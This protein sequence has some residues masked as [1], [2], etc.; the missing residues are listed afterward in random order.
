VSDTRVFDRPAT[1]QSFFE[2][3]IGDFLDVGRPE[4]V[5]LLFDRPVS[6]RTAGTSLRKGLIV[7]LPG[8]HRYQLTPR[9]RRIAVLVTKVYRRVLAPGLVEL[10]PRIPTDL[11]QPTQAPTAT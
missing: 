9:G 6:C 5:S 2:G 8:R 11:A 1:E 4:S 7:R 10:D 3:L